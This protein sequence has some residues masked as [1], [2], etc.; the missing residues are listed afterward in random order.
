MRG[1]R[2]LWS[3]DAGGA[4]SSNDQRQM[5]QLLSAIV[6]YGQ[7]S[8]VLNCCQLLSAIVN[9]CQLLSA[10]GSCC[11]LLSTGCA[12]SICARSSEQGVRL[13]QKMQVGCKWIRALARWRLPLWRCA[14]GWRG[15]GG[16]W[17]GSH[18]HTAPH[19]CIILT[20]PRTFHQG[21][22]VQNTTLYL[23]C[24]SVTHK[25]CDVHL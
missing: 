1:R 8:T 15:G 17:R 10:V 7:L 4:T 20:P 11:Q 19:N 13:A 6:S 9:C 21:F 14:S 25:S 22:A 12:C 18:S 2:L 5:L 23:S 16:G 3:R 24:T